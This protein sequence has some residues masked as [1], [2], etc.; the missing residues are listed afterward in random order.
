[1]GSSI[2]AVLDSKFFLKMFLGLLEEAN[3][4]PETKTIFTKVTYYY[5]LLTHI[6]F[7]KFCDLKNFKMF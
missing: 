4:L 5:F 7:T 2:I 3:Y 1:M 6:D